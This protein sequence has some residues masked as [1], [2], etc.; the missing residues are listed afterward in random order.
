MP[1]IIVL[2][3]HEGNHPNTISPRTPSSRACV[4]IFIYIYNDLLP[5]TNR[6]SPILPG[7]LAGALPQPLVRGWSP[8]PPSP[9]SSS[10]SSSSEISDSNSIS[11]SS[12]SSPTSDSTSESISTSTS[13]SAS[14]SLLL[15]SLSSKDSGPNCGRLTLAS[16]LLKRSSVRW[17]NSSSLSGVAALSM[18]NLASS[19]SAKSSR[20]G[21][22]GDT[23]RSGTA[24]IHLRTASPFL[25]R[26]PPAH[27]SDRARWKRRPRLFLRRTARSR[28]YQVMP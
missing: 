5:Q 8:I 9:S 18:S 26:P 20:T 4:Q 17:M 25:T 11:S 23:N 24:A 3:L 15:L 28:M 14:S 19:A 22:L 1:F 12:T 16:W 10:R 7:H 27:R 13:A 2:H 21:L 6:Y